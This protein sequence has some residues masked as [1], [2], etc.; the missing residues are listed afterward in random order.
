MAARQVT[1]LGGQALRNAVHLHFYPRLRKLDESR[2][3]VRM[4][5]TYGPLLTFKNLKYD[6]NNPHPGSA[7]AIFHDAA[8]A[9]RLLKDSPLRFSLIPADVAR[10]YS[11]VDGE[12]NMDS[13]SK[14]D[15]S[16]RLDDSKQRSNMPFYDLGRDKSPKLFGLQT[17]VAEITQTQAAGVDG[18]GDPTSVRVDTLNNPFEYRL[19]ADVPTIKY[20]GLLQRSPFHGPFH[21]NVGTIEF[22]D[23]VENVPNYGLAELS[24]KRT[25]TTPGMLKKRQAAVESRVRLRKLVEMRDA[26]MEVD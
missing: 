9:A 11:S 5:E 13:I 24:L 8:S 23:L 22:L 25:E 14:I 21:P 16:R 7:L 10:S 6:F 20:D 2:E 1:R 3:V 12:L 15:P 17:S 4:L 26:G 19:I 18:E